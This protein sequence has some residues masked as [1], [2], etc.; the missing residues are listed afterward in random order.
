MARWIGGRCEKNKH[1]L[2]AR[3]ASKRAETD[4][5][6]N[7]MACGCRYAL[8]RGAFRGHCGR[9]FYR[10]NGLQLI[11]LYEVDNLVSLA[12]RLGD[13]S[14]AWPGLPWPPQRPRRFQP[15]CC[16]QRTLLGL[17]AR[18]HDAGPDPDTRLRPVRHPR[19]RLSNRESRDGRS[20]GT[21]SIQLFGRDIC[22]VA[23]A[24][25]T[26][27]HNHR[28]AD[29]RAAHHGLP[30]SARIQPAAQCACEFNAGSCCARRMAN[31]AHACYRQP[32]SAS[33]VEP[34]QRCA[35]GGHRLA[36]QSL[37]S[38]FPIPWG[39]GPMRSIGS[40]GS[41]PQAAKDTCR[42]HSAACRGGPSPASRVPLPTHVGR[43]EARHLT[44]PLFQSIPR[45]SPA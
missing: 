30:V 9:K 13:R 3:R 33:M 17:H 27:Q 1:G 37:A 14:A 10:N 38:F 24:S 29:F 35:G 16:R 18:Q 23:T 45:A 22:L 32:S 21:G 39:S 4:R 34:D 2:P 5:I 20:A 6:S 41:R 42:R 12:N 40:K 11:S 31:F 7:D 43:K 36:L 25:F 8:L 28:L 44:F 15:T 19:R 26:A